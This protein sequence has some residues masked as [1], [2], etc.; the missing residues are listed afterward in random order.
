M[1]NF[2]SFQIGVTGHL[3][4]QPE[5]LNVGKTDLGKDKRELTKI[6]QSFQRAGIS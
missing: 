3:G 4:L 1:G 2:V 6:P 5:P